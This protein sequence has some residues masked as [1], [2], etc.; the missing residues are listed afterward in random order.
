[1]IFLRSRRPGDEVFLV[2]RT[3]IRSHGWQ[4]QSGGVAAASMRI[5]FDRLSVGAAQEVVDS[6]TN[7]AGGTGWSPDLP[8]SRRGK[9]PVEV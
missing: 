8:V 2:V 1:M 5:F 3:P 4:R 6:Q 9:R 7:K